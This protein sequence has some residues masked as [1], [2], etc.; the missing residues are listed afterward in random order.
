MTGID[1]TAGGDR[2][3]ISLDPINPDDGVEEE[4]YI[5]ATLRYDPILTKSAENTKASFNRPCPFKNGV[6]IPGGRYDKPHFLGSH[7]ISRF[8]VVTSNP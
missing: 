2:E 1:S 8:D 3:T 7:S 5:F 6:T 4:P